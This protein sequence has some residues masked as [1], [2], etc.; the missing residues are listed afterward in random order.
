[1]LLIFE[2]SVFK[3]MFFSLHYLH[4]LSL[5]RNNNNWSTNSIKASQPIKNIFFVNKN[6][7]LC[8]LLDI[9]VLFSLVFFIILPVLLAAAYILAQVC[10]FI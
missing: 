8:N 4:N 9:F 10:I 7:P 6:E 1:M 2:F 3:L 5:H